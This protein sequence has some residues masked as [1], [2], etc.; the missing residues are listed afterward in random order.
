M[1]LL[2]HSEPEDGPGKV[3]LSSQLRREERSC[4]KSYSFPVLSPGQNRTKRELSTCWPNILTSLHWKM[5][6]WGAPKWPNT[7]SK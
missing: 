7:K 3:M 6:R 1:V 5:V 4:L 2:E